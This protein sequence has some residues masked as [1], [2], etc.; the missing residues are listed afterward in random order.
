[1]VV[2]WLAG[3]GFPE[4]LHLVYRPKQTVDPSGLRNFQKLCFRGREGNVGYGMLASAYG[5]GFR[6]FF[7]IN[8]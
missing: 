8:G 2:I 3:Y 1:M 5:Q 4:D 7:A 6:P